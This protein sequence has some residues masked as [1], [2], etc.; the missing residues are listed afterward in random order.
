MKIEILKQKG[1]RFLW[2]ND[3]LWMWDIPIEQK[4]QKR[5]A[6]EAYGNVLVAGYGLGIVQKYLLQNKRVTSVITTEIHPKIEQ[7][8]KEEYGRI[9]GEIINIDFYNYN[10]I[11]KFYCIVGDVWEEI[12]PEGLEEY[13]KFK[14]KANQLLY[15]GG[16]ILAWGKNYFEYL[17]KGE[18]L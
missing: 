3:Y 17:I 1:N 5:I 13:K 7:L 12:A 14:N 11:S 9:Y 6:S 15:S 18:G 10:P 4:I 2:I 8:C 16:K